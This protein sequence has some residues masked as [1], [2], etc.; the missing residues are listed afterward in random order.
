MSFFKAKT[1]CWEGGGVCGGV[2]GGLILLPITFSPAHFARRVWRHFAEV[3]DEE[4]GSSF[5]SFLSSFIE[6][7]VLINAQVSAVPMEAASEARE[8]MVRVCE[9]RSSHIRQG[10]YVLPENGCSCSMG[11]SCSKMSYHLSVQKQAVTG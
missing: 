9:L 6:A 10:Y 5:I 8:K 2:C 3:G 11:S 4:R 7:H 1:K